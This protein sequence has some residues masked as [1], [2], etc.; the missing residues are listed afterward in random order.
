MKSIKFPGATIEI[1]KGQED[2]YN[3]LHAMPVP[4][5]EGEVVVCFELAPEEIKRINETGKIY[6]SQWTFFQKFSP[7]RLSVDLDERQQ[8][9][10]DQH[11]EPT[12]KDYPKADELPIE[13]K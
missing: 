9:L 10:S 6:Y 5:P 11:I 7:M 3:V 4:G 8:K 12:D 1:G 2:I 13:E